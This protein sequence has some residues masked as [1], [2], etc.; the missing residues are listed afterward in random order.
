[1]YQCSR[2]HGAVAEHDDACMVLRATPIWASQLMAGA[3]AAHMRRVLYSG[4]GVMSRFEKC[5][6][7][8]GQH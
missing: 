3:V 2:L 8:A 5:G 4:A 6:A 1:M 7:K